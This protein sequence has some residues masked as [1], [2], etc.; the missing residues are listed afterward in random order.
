MTFATQLA[1]DKDGVLRAVPPQRE[2]LAL[3]TWHTAGAGTGAEAGAVGN[4]SGNIET[5]GAGA[6]AGA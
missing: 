4:G 6:T 2:M 5:A 1:N 3:R